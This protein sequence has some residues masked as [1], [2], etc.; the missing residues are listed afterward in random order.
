MPVHDDM[1]SL[2][3]FPALASVKFSNTPELYYIPTP[4]HESN[5]RPIIQEAREFRKEYPVNYKPKTD[6]Q[7]LRDAQASARMLRSTIDGMIQGANPACKFKCKTEFGCNE[8]IAAN[9]A[10]GCPAQG[11]KSAPTVDVEWIADTGSAQDPVSKRDLQGLEEFES[12]KPVNMMT[13]NGPSYRR[14]PE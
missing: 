5:W 14:P 7:D 1:H 10:V 2:P 8:C 13:A 3:T 4:E 6:G 9:I 12:S 11:I